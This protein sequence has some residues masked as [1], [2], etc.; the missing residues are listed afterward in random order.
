MNKMIFY[1]GAV[2]FFFFYL[3]GY[4][5]NPVEKLPV[6]TACGIYGESLEPYLTG[7][8]DE[9]G[10][11]LE[12]FVRENKVH[13]LIRRVYTKMCR[14]KGKFPRYMVE[15][16]FNDRLMFTLSHT[17]I[18]FAVNTYYRKTKYRLI[19]VDAL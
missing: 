7:I 5:A 18:P 12:G 17:D 8:F 14:D 6:N 9:N 1:I 13:V 2:F 15:V 10:G 19:C 3:R 11:T 16:S 4:E